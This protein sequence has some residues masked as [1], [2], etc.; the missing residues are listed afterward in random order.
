MLSGT[1][2]VAPVPRRCSSAL[3][4]KPHFTF[5]HRCRARPTSFHRFHSNKAVHFRGFLSELNSVLLQ[6][7]FWPS[8]PGDSLL[9][10]RCM[11][12]SI[13]YIH[14]RNGLMSLELAV[15]ASNSSPHIS[16]SGREPTRVHRDKSVAAL[17]KPGNYLRPASSFGHRS[18]ISCCST[19]LAA[20]VA[21]RHVRL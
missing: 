11:Q 13:V 20:V 12:Q 16:D 8:F 4:S 2:D 19:S 15:Q 3:T 1:I 6:A 14:P 7:T 9:N 17:P 5:G 10:W 18:V 21:F